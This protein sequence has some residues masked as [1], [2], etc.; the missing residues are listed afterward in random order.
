MRVGAHR[1]AGRTG[2]PRAIVKPDLLL[3]HVRGGRLRGFALRREMHPFMPS[4]LLRV[5]GHDPFDLDP[6]S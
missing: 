3:E 5:P 4:V 6:E 2:T 1:G